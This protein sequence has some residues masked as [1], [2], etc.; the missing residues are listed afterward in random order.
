MCYTI[1]SY[2]LQSIEPLRRRFPLK[3][4]AGYL[5]AAIIGAISWALMQM[6]QKF[7]TLVDMVFPYVLRILQDTL[8]EWS[9]GL[10]FCLWQTLAV[11]GGALVIASIVLMVVM[12]W[13][14]IQWGG[15]VLAAASV[16]V[17][18]HTLTFGLNYHAGPLADDIQLEVKEYNL[19]ELTLATTYYRDMANLAADKVDRNAEGE[20]DFGE[21]EDI[22]KE[23][24]N[25]FDHLI[26]DYSY[27]VFAGSNLPVK[28]LGWANMYSS[29]GITG[30]FCGITGEAAVNPQIP[31]VTLPFTMCHE[32]SHRK[33]I[34]VERDANFS[35]FLACQAND[36]VNYRYSG[37]FMAYRYCLSQLKSL[38]IESAKKIMAQE[39]PELSQDM[40]TYSDFFSS[41]KDEKA[42]KVANTV[43]DTYLKANG[44]EMGIASYDNVCGMLVN[45][46]IQEILTPTY[47]EEEVAFDPFDESQV[48][49]SG[50]TNA[51]IVETE[52]TE[53]VGGVG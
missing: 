13:N 46:Y 45:W 35:A 21:F 14:P 39:R 8:S 27:P 37:Y 22:A 15:W 40:A 48:D 12:R 18:L 47:T 33:S 24:G 32:M 34:A 19:I 36:N 42:T 38:D 51:I 5:T 30:F 17:L 1:T 50:I 43:N 49:L 16:V 44:D 3:Y 20:A 23:A 2:M 25:G 52:P 53:P 29:M 6:A 9:A 4:W 28:K 10:D 26:Y 11:A 41:R 31:H 7:T